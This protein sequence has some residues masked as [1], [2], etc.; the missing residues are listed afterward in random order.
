MKSYVSYL[1]GIYSSLLSTVV[2]HYPHLRSDCDRDL[3]RL[4]S[5]IDTRGHSFLM[6]DLPAIGKHFDLCL[7]MG[8]L[9]P[10]YLPGN[11]PY[12][13]GRAIPR[14]FK[15]M[16]LRVF[17]ENGVLRADSDVA[18]IRFLRQ[19]Y[20]A[21]K[22][23]KITCDDSRTWKQVHE[24]FETDREVE[25]PSLNWDEDRLRLDGL[26]DLHFGDRRNPG[27]AP[28]LFPDL[29][30]RASVEES[31]S[32]SSGF[33]ECVQQVADIVSA[34]LGRFDPFEWRSKH[35]P[36]AVADQRHTDFK[37]DF[38]S[39][40]A[41]LSEVFPLADFGFA[42]FGTWS[43]SVRSG[44]IHKRF[45]LNEYPSRLIAVPK[46]LKAPRL[47][48]SEPV[49]HQW[50]QQTIKDYLT[51]RLRDTPIRSTIHFRDQTENQEFARRA[52]H[53]Q[54]HVTVDLSE[55]SDRL[56]CWVVERCFRRLPSLVAAFHASRTRWV[57][58]TIDRK[59]PNYYKLR[60]FACMGS[61]CTFPVQSY[62]F[63]IASIAA[64]LYSR[65]LRPSIKSVRRV[66]QEVRVFGDDMI[67]PTDGWDRLQEVLRHLRLKINHS[68]T[69]YTGKFRESCGLD[70]WDGQDV[71]PV[72]TMTHPEVSRPESIA[73]SVATHNNYVLRGYFETAGFLQSRLSKLRHITLARVPIGSGVF[74]LYDYEFR[75][76]P[77]VKRRYNPDTHVVEYRVHTL[78][79]LTGRDEVKD[80]S[81]L[82]Q[83]FT[84]AQVPP[85]RSGERLGK[86][87]RPSLNLRRRWVN[88]EDRRGESQYLSS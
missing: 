39:W 6:I 10:S 83:Y 32:I 53:T 74:G 62:V 46:T 20:Y 49:S 63:A 42:N 67:V 24:F 15:G 82:L 44:D 85:R 33:A 12:K 70:A 61:A 26:R 21:A 58:N 69:F 57:V 13:K 3:S 40:P 14:L 52:S 87:R 80:D 28:L 36:G 16:L 59:S 72:Y 68:K 60:K 30:D 43:A 47:I 54:S 23:V 34:S 9:T 37:Y 77:G 22:K 81:V 11:R 5:L 25:S 55:A 66:S 86:A 35:G 29:D 7:S 48:A 75:G 65:G 2:E 45:S 71:T 76:N 17:D 1:Q 41:K 19:L 78:T 18:C 56:S 38:P 79:A 4:L 88:L 84:E 50:C 73:S 51:S 27:P 64:V 8:H 31:I